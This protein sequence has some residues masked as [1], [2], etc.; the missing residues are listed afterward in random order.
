VAKFFPESSKRRCRALV[1]RVRV[2]LEKRLNEVEWMTSPDTR[3]QAL[4]KMAAFGCK[5]GFPDE[6]IDYGPLEIVAGDHLGNILRSRAFEHGICLGRVDKPTDLK[7]WEML[8]HQINAYYHPNLNEIVFPAAILQPPFFDASAD[9]ATNLGSMGVVVGHE[10][11]HGFDD[12][13]RQR[14]PA[15]ESSLDARRG[16]AIE[17]VTGLGTTPRATCGT[18]GRP[19]TRP[20]TRSGSM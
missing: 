5:I 14:R 11:T 20:S 8:P 17:I 1:E 16:T 15:R 10:M 6:F 12:Q 3:R 18:G 4:D 13:G 2:Q 19:R 9:D 7:K